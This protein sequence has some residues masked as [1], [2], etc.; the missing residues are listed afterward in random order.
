[1]YWEQRQFEQA[2]Q[3][4]VVEL[5]KFPLDDEAHLRIG[6][7]LLS[8]GK[9]GEAVPQL[10]TALQVNKRSWEL[11]RALGQASMATGDMAKAQSWLESA[12]QQNPSDA[13]SHQLLAEVY[14]TTG[15]SDWSQREQSIFIK[16]S[17][18][19]RN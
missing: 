15:H 14:R 19:E 3:E 1:M 10:E 5:Q 4:Y 6:E 2:S 7:Y 16:L 12:I 13:L 18:A 11:D 17:A 8:Q 9:V